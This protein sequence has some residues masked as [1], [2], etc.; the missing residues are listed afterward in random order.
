MELKFYCDPAAAMLQM[1]CSNSTD[2]KLHHELG[3][4][5]GNLKPLVE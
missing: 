2:I 1:R 3:V 4:A 5:G